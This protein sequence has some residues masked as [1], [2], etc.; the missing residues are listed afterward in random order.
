VILL[1]L[2]CAPHLRYEPVAFEVPALHLDHAVLTSAV[3]KQLERG[4]IRSIERPSELGDSPVPGAQVASLSDA[5]LYAV[6]A[7]SGRW[8]RGAEL[9]LLVPAAD[10]PTPTTIWVDLE[11]GVRVASG[12]QPLQAPL[13]P[14]HVDEL[15]WQAEIAESYDLDG[16]SGTWTLIELGYVV[17]ALDRLT[18]EEL[19]AMTG[20]HFARVAQ[21][22]RRAAEMARYEPSELPPRLEVYDAAFEEF[23]HGFVGPLDHPVP[24]PV[25]TVLHECGHVIV[26]RPLRET[27]DA[28][29]MAL[30]ASEGMVDGQAFA[31]AYDRAQEIERCYRQLGSTGPVLDQFV[32]IRG[33]TRGP[34]SYGW[35]SRHHE[36]F[37]EAFALHHLDPDALRRVMPAVSEWFDRDQ[38]VSTGDF[39]GGCLRR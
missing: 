36:A 23:G 32:A 15:L 13:P 22:P 26:D 8:S 35:R 20:V 38:H 17:M 2:A 21:S 33:K 16:F 30:E 3:M 12:T 24:T 34:T 14:A 6:L 10:G 18:P 19:A 27:Y 5:E 11:G 31:S 1:A 9:D 37:A 39:G 7:A 28:F 4:R 29:R 25:M